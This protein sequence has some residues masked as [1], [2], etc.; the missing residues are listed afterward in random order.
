M[1]TNMDSGGQLSWRLTPHQ[2][3]TVKSTYNF[4]VNPGIPTPIFQGIWPLKLPPRL[5]F[6]LWL[7]LHNRLHTA[8]NLQCKGWSAITSCIMYNE[9][10]GEIINHL[11]V[12]CPN[13][14]ALKR[15]INGVVVTSSNNNTIDE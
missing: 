6:F 9:Q 10:I 11:F 3:F 7:A 4:I 15:Q 14:M 8:N 5:K 13:R 1:A 12:T 2:K